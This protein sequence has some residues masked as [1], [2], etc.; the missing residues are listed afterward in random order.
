MSDEHNTDE[1]DML[2]AIRWYAE[3]LDNHTQGTWHAGIDEA[4]SRIVCVD[5]YRHC[6][7]LG[8]DTRVI[9]PMA[10]VAGFTVR[11]GRI[12]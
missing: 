7:R 10:R 12:Q 8:W 6:R 3:C 4:R 5:A 2:V 11:G 9:N 1:I